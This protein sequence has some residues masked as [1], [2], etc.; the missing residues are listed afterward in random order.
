MYATQMG[1][2]MAQDAESDLSQ[3]PVTVDTSTL[4][5]AIND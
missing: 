5:P 1:L 4:L 3:R 2:V